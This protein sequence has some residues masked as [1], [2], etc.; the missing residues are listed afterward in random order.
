MVYFG[1]A[2]V[3]W[4]IV[5][6][7]FSRSR[8]PKA[9]P[10]DGKSIINR[11]VT[12]HAEDLA[13]AIFIVIGVLWTYG[14]YYYPDAPIRRCGDGFCGKHGPTRTLAEFQSFENWEGLFIFTF[15]LGFLSVLYLKTKLPS[16][17]RG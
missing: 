12:R 10:D 17:R 6:F 16:D 9:E 7:F 2:L 4:S 14:V 1:C 3:V 13:R 8:E 15:I 11:W 5:G